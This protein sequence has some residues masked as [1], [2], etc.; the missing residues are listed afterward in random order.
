MGQWLKQ[1]LSLRRALV[2]IAL[3][4]ICTTG[5]GST[6]FLY[7]SHHKEQRALDDHYYIVAVV[8][9]GPDKEALPTSY[10]AELLDLS[11]DRPT[12]LYRFD[13]KKGVKKLL[14]SPLIKNATIQKVIP[15]T[16][17]I[18][19]AL[20]TPVA[21][22][23]DYSNTAVDS[24]G[25][26]IPFKPFFT[27]KRLPTLYVGANHVEGNWNEHASGP[28]VDLALKLLHELSVECLEKGITLLSIDTSNAFSASYGQREIVVTLEDQVQKEN[29][30]QMTLCLWPTL[31]RLDTQ[32][33]QDGWK[34]Y[35]LLRK[36][37]QKS[38]K[39]LV[40]DGENPVVTL[41][42]V[43]V[44]LRISDIAFINK[45]TKK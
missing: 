6:A 13:V 29:L 7:Y 14:G 23:G 21:F 42:T 41:S 43:V 31:L 32:H 26:I 38:I 25:Y 27:P 22:L 16:L 45:V 8:Q 4:T 2:W 18:D 36:Q 15:G 19:Y 37:L 1:K 12:N 24:E 9:T 44:N 33:Y 30:G 5:I 28:E 40:H 10:L 34:D 35:L 11:V 17:Y 39:H 3:S 20:R